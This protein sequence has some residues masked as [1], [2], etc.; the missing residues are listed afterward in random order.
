MSAAEN[1]VQEQANGKP[2][3][4]K[5]IVT[6]VK[7]SDGRKV[8]FAGKRD[9]VKNYYPD[10]AQATVKVVL[11]FRNGETRTFY[12]HPSLLLTFA[13]HGAIQ[14]LGDELADPKLTD[15]DDK[16]AAIDSLIAQL[17]TGEWSARRE[18]DEF[19]GTSVLLK[20]LVELTQ[21]EGEQPADAVTRVK[22]F[23]KGKS[24]NEKLALRNSPKIKPIVERIEAE[25][26]AKSAQVD[27]DSL[28]AELGA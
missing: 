12:P 23:L 25:K 18:G 5:T 1:K 27:T 19:A 9:L 4:P 3:K 6:T 15:I 26:A 24:Q 14:K 22:A 20:A 17:D 13:G 2:A 28:L 7:M 21:K 16:I 8:D 11:D 10:E